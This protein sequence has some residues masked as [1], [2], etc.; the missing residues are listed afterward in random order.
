MSQRPSLAHL[1]ERTRHILPLLPLAF[2]L[3]SMACISAITPR[4]RQITGANYALRQRLSLL[5]LLSAVDMFADHNQRVCAPYPAVSHLSSPLPSP[6]PTPAD[7]T[8]RIRS[9]C[10]WSAQA[11]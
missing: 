1:F 11:E 8:R 6:P 10:V 3:N 4:S 5:A 2:C 9:T 7:T